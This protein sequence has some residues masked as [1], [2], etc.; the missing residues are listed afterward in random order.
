MKIKLLLSF[1]FLAAIASGQTSRHIKVPGTKCSIIPPDGFVPATNFSGFQNA[2]TGA[3]IMI[4]EIPVSYQSIENSFTAEELKKRGMMLESKQLIDFNNSKALLIRVRQT[5]NESIY[6]KQ[7]LIFG[8]TNKTVLVNG[9]YPEAI[10]EIEVEIKEAL[11][12]TVYTES[13]PDNPIEAANFTI[14]VSGTGFKAVKY[15]SGSLLY[16]IDGKIP[17]DKPTLIIGNSVSSVLP[18]NQKQYAEERL[19]K[20]PQ[21]EFSE[22]KEI[23]KITIDGLTGYE[24]V[25]NGKTHENKPIIIYQVIIFN[26]KGDYYI[27]TGRSEEE[28]QKYLDVFRKVAKTFKRKQ[29]NLLTDEKS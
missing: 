2:K 16:S 28:H 6:I 23:R 19:K 14:D 4:N 10:N 9:I 13:Q 5:A 29:A 18:E 27:I 11:F 26:D 25:A 15:M 20:L 21:G 24:I 1:F 12:S 3:S 17:T 22:I 8:D 7:L